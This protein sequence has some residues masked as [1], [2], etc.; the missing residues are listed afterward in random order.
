MFDPNRKLVNMLAHKYL[1]HEISKK[2]SSEDDDRTEDAS[3]IADQI[4]RHPKVQKKLDTVVEKADNLEGTIFS[5]VRHDTVGAI[6]AEIGEVINVGLD[7]AGDSIRSGI[8]GVDTISLGTTLYGSLNNL[9]KS[10]SQKTGGTRRKFKRLRKN[11][12]T[13]KHKRHKAKK[14]KKNRKKKTKRH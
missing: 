8:E 13:N 1:T 12:K 7:V 10:K 14:S 5:Q 11:K 2:I 6:P 4:L 3:E 9:P